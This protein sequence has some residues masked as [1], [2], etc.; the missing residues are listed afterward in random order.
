[1]TELW[2]GQRFR[3]LSYFLDNS[4]ETLYPVTCSSCFKIISS[5]VISA[6]SD[7]DIECMQEKINVLC[8]PCKLTLSYIKGDPHNQAVL[9]HFHGWNPQSTSSSHSLA[10]ITIANA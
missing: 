4:K 7:F 10:T 9:I 2:H 5:D 1:M 8:P 3:E 6:S